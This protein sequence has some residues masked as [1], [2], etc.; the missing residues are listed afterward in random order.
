MGETD[1]T[2]VF[3]TYK[4]Y[5]YQMN[6]SGGCGTGDP[7]HEPAVRTFNKVVDSIQLK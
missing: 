1:E 2:F 3:F 5:I 4:D 7:A 6:L